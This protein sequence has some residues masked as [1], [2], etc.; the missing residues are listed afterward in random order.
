MVSTKEI[1][2]RAM[3]KRKT[4]KKPE[5]FERVNVLQAF[6]ERNY[7]QRQWKHSEQDRVYF[8]LIII[9]GN[10]LIKKK[11]ENIRIYKEKQVNH[12]CVD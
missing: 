10:Q 2:V 1:K 3:P 5:Q 9:I 6:L 4:N 8:Y 12:K 7:L 11:K